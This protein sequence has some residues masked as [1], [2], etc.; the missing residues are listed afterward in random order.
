[1]RVTLNGYVAADEDLPIYHFFKYPAFGP[2]T[3]RQALE[4]C[5][6]DEELVFEI[7]SYG[8]SVFSGGE[9]YSVLRSSNRQTRAE[10]QSLAASAA[11]YLALGCTEVWISP[12]AQMMVHLPSTCTQGDRWDHLGT[13]R[14]LDSTTEAILNA[15][16]LK[17]KGKKNRDE[18]RQLMGRT[19]WLTAQDALDAGLADGILYQEDVDPKTI[20]NAAGSGLRAVAGLCGMPDLETL[21]A[22]YQKQH[23]QAGDPAGNNTGWQKL[24]NQ[25]MAI[26][27]IRF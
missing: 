14:A 27:K 4:D 7:N 1:M 6:A 11:S 13:V 17:S 19:E 10:I 5:P 23:D 25:R 16:E 15:Y 20:V 18:L 3:V 26:E 12:V 9:I 2:S 8:G 22:E 21:R 24:A